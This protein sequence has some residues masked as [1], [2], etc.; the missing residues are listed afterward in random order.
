MH[1]CMYLCTNISSHAHGRSD[2]C[3]HSRDFVFTMCPPLSGCHRAAPRICLRGDCAL[4]R[5]WLRR[6]ATICQ[7]R[8]DRRRA[9]HHVS[10]GPHLSHLN[11]RACH[12]PDIHCLHHHH[13]GVDWRHYRVS[14]G[15]A[16]R[17][18]WAA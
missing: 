17:R 5:S 9:R 1:A 3:T 18:R 10:V 16:C 2:A 8:Q 13:G 6:H 15:V 4:Q 7:Q 14:R 12:P 11:L